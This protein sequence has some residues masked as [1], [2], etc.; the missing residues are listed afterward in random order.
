[1]T[2]IN[3]RQL[4]PKSRRWIQFSQLWLAPDHLMLLKSSRFTEEYSRYRLEDIEA[5][6]V[7]SLD[8]EPLRD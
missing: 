6:V 2:K 3:Y 4:T 5:V 7:T 1:M 8:G